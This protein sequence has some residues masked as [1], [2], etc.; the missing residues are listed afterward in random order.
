LAIKLYSILTL[1]ARRIFSFIKEIERKGWRWI[2]KINVIPCFLDY[3]HSEGLG[4]EMLAFS[5]ASMG[6]SE[7]G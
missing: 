7:A 1:P 5:G 6:V 3:C 4:K 2:Y